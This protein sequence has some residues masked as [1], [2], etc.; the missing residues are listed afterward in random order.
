MASL[1]GDA[2]VEILDSSCGSKEDEFSKT[3]LNI[4]VSDL[5][6]PPSLYVLAGLRSEWLKPSRCISAIFLFVVA[7]D[8]R[9]SDVM[10]YFTTALPFKLNSLVTPTVWVSLLIVSSMDGSNWILLK[11]FVLDTCVENPPFQRYSSGSG[12]SVTFWC[13]FC[14][15]RDKQLA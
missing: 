5:A 6:S 14:K 15:Y 9:Y 2:L 1:K 7:Q 13:I 8:H 12:C 3:A 4:S 11:R 10:K